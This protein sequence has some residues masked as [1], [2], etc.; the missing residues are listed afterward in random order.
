VVE[1]VTLGR[2]GSNRADRTG[3]QPRGPSCAF[4]VDPEGTFPTPCVDRE[5]TLWPKT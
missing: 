5:T 2:D 1:P 4:G 3:H